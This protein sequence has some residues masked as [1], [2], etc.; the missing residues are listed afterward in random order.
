[1]TTETLNPDDILSA[2][3]LADLI[4]DMSIDE[5]NEAAV[6]NSDASITGASTLPDFRPR[7][8]PT[9]M[10]LDEL[11]RVGVDAMASARVG[12]RP[13][14]FRR[15]ISDG[16]P[17]ALVTVNPSGTARIWGPKDA[18]LLAYQVLQPVFSETFNEM[19]NEVEYKYSTS[20]PRDPAAALYEAAM[21][22]DAIPAVRTISSTPIVLTTG[23]VAA[24]PGYNP[25][26]QALIAIPKRDQEAWTTR[27][28]V[29]L[30]PTAEEAQAALDYVDVELLSDFPF[31][32]VADRA[33][34]LTFI[35]T[36]ATRYLFPMCPAFAADAPE[37]GT[38]KSWLCELPRLVTLGHAKYQSVGHRKGQD[39]ETR[40]QLGTLVL[41]GSSFFAHI[42]E[43]P[44]D[45]KLTST[46][47]QELVTAP[48]MGVRVL[49]VNANVEAEGLML[50]MAGNN[51]Q[52]GGDFGRRVMKARLRYVGKGTAARRDPS[53]FR[54]DDLRA[55]VLDH[56][57]ELL[58]AVHTIVI[59]GIQNHVQP[60]GSMG[61]FEAWSRTVGRG[62]S[63]VTLEVADDKG[64][65][66]R[67]SVFKLALDAQETVVEKEDDLTDEWGELLAAWHGEFPN[68]EW[69]SAKEIRSR[70]I[71]LLPKPGEEG[72]HIPDPLVPRFGQSDPGAARAWSA[73]IKEIHQTRMVYGDDRYEAHRKKDRNTFMFRVTK[74]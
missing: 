23:H 44:R 1:M 63:A 13:Y 70:I 42:D 51:I 38:G 20:F 10:P 48:S 29:P 25:E 47:L 67:V 36:A 17:N 60:S 73:A 49:G 52:I 62:L 37:K 68:E 31:E 26:H 14:L 12:G 59:Y 33:T 69:V 22:S 24:T 2:A 30:K 28:N 18:H 40:K 65:T 43:M 35:T 72:L 53:D 6:E 4:G 7:V 66:S 9:E 45:E 19:T 15:V 74:V 27:Y 46:A 41:S 57:P 21:Q 8:N 3:D 61:S 16:T 54:H 5:M 56:R 71:Q 32:S 39:E 34:E 64:V 58:A 11:L 55:W 50:S